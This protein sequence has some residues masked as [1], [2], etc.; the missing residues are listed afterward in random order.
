VRLLRQESPSLATILQTVDKQS[1]NFMAEQVL[2]AMGAAKHGAPGT[3]AKGIEVVRAYLGELGLD[4]A[5]YALVNG[6]GLSR[7]VL[8]RPE[9]LTAVLYDMY[10][11]QRVGPEFRTAL[12]I[13]G[14]DGT[15][16][17]RFRAGD[18]AGRVRGKT[19]SLNG[20]YCL[21]GYA[22]AADGEVYGFAFLLNEIQG[23]VS[24]A[25]SLQDR[26]VEALLGLGVAA[27][28]AA[29]EEAAVEEGAE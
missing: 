7:D 17:S 23:P 29:A 24:R 14:L 20:V 13:G 5:S 22:D 16:R 6:S 26:V 21:T 8:L 11:D 4:P 28:V 3:T 2:K 25:R 12:S 18:L 27:E 1:N 19:G 10:G 9:V 15:L